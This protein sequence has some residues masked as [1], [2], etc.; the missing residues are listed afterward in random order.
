[1]VRKINNI[2]L[3]LSLYLY[4][5]DKKHIS[6]KMVIPSHYSDKD[7]QNFYDYLWTNGN[8]IIRNIHMNV[9]DNYKYIILKTKGYNPYKDDLKRLN[10]KLYTNGIE[11]KLVYHK[12]TSYY[13]KNY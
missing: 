11:L 7:I 3:Y 9:Q 4:K 10:L 8:G 2:V 12:N 5:V 13:F 1:M 6:S